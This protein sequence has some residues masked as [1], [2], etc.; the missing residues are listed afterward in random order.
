LNSIDPSLTFNYNVWKWNILQDRADTS[1]SDKG[2]QRPQGQLSGQDLSQCSL[3]S[4]SLVS[5]QW[6]FWP[7]SY[8]HQLARPVTRMMW[9]NAS[10]LP[11]LFSVMKLSHTD[12]Y[13]PQNF[14][15]THTSWWAWSQSNLS[16]SA[17]LRGTGGR[18]GEV[19]TSPPPYCRSPAVELLLL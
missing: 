11:P 13:A 18:G 15:Q 19:T 2:G 17:L 6:K 14:S 1:F 8:Q 10:F 9:G 3:W 4:G 5:V 16:A 7:Q 12:C